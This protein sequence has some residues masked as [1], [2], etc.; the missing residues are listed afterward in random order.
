MKVR[1]MAE[2]LGTTFDWSEEQ[3]E[4]VV[5][6]LDDATEGLVLSS[7]EDGFKDGLEEGKGM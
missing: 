5:N 4:Y 6:F 7:Y 3:I 2:Y 1:E